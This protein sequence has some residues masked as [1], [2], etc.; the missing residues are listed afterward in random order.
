M[1][2]IK[3]TFQK[4]SLKKSLVML[5]ALCLG[6][7][8]ILSIITILI[9]SDMQQKILDTRPIVVT[10]YT[11]KN[12]EGTGSETTVVPQKYIYK[13]LSKDNQI[14]YWIV[15]ILMVILPVIYIIAA[16]LMVA[17]FYYK[18]K[19]Q[20][21][22]QNLKN[23][24]YHISQQD[25]DFQ[26]QYTTDDELG[27]LCDTFECMRNEIHKSNC[28]MWDMLQERK[29]LTASISHDLRTPI[30]VV[31]GY[32]DYLEKSME[33]KMLTE[34]LLQTTIKNMAGAMSRLERYVDYVKD[35]QKM[36]EIEIRKEQYNLKEIIADITREF[37]VLAAQYGRKLIIHDLSQ[38]AFIETDK[39]MLSKILEN[40]FDNA[41]R[42][43]TD[44]IVLSIDE[45]KD[46]ICFSIQDDGVGFTAEELNSATSFFYSS[47]T[48]GGNFGIGLS[49]CKI[50]C[51]KL[52]GNMC[53]GNNFDCGAIITIKIKK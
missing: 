44:K 46:Y 26:I 22:L 33:R 51:E 52:G 23:G 40:I 49:I 50:L 24:M 25:L 4:M 21:P 37:S 6:G 18:L 11:M 12:H 30:T 20:I 3:N 35:I 42:F 8:S 1:G 47:P 29:A 9:F 32:L 14:Y 53:L 19:L 10:D 48:N 43:S 13:E 5:A 16:S 36:E 39:D 7:V 28:K 2:K 31:N 34:E 41:L 27:K 17:K 38:D 45:K 15:T